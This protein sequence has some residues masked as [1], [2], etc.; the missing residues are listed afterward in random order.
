MVFTLLSYAADF[1]YE[2]TRQ[3]H[4]PQNLFL[5]MK[6]RAFVCCDI[7]KIHF[8]WSSRPTETLFKCH[9]NHIVHFEACATTARQWLTRIKSIAHK[10]LF[11][12]YTFRRLSVLW[13]QQTN[14]NFLC[15][16]LPRSWKMQF[17]FMFKEKQKE[18]FK[19][20]LWWVHL[21]LAGSREVTA[22]N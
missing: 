14:S 5:E 11:L 1:I 12:I 4:T 13:G 15:L 19:N 10:T 22:M 21:S 6:K 8:H 18:M 3:N 7:V 17:C 20:V 9:Q 16:N 2:K